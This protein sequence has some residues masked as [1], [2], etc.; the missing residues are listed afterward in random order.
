MGWQGQPLL[1]FQH[2]NLNYRERKIHDQN[3]FSFSSELGQVTFFTCKLLSFIQF[4]Q[5]EGRFSRSNKHTT[6]V[7]KS[8]TL[9]YRLLLKAPN[10][11]TGKN[12]CTDKLRRLTFCK[13][14]LTCCSKSKLYPFPLYISNASSLAAGE[15]MFNPNW[16]EAGHFPPPCP[17]WIKF[18]QLNFYQKFPN[19]FGGEN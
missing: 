18:C 15:M 4:S 9:P 6:K 13:K 3:K 14:K 11:H 16:H 17:F 5:P 10:K 12:K 2:A 1:S 7:V 19:F 8:Q